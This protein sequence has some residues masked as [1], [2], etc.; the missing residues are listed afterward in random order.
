MDFE[1]AQQTI[2]R[3]VR[4]QRRRDT[5]FWCAF[6]C[7]VL[8]LGIAAKGLKGT[9]FY[10]RAID[11]GSIKHWA[12]LDSFRSYRGVTPQPTYYWVSEKEV[13]YFQPTGMGTYQGYLQQL[14]PVAS[15]PKI[16][17]RAIVRQGDIP[18]GLSPDRNWLCYF[19]A[20]RPSR[21]WNAANMSYSLIPL[22]PQKNSTAHLRGGVIWN[23]KGETTK[24]FFNDTI[25]IFPK[26]GAS[27][28]A[29]KVP[30]L[31]SINNYGRN[32]VIR[33]TE[34]NKVLAT[35]GMPYIRRHTTSSRGT[36]FSLQGMTLI[37]IDIAS[38]TQGK[39]LRRWKIMGPDEQE[40]GR[41]Y[42]SPNSDQILWVIHSNPRTTWDRIVR[43]YINL[44]SPDFKNRVQG[45]LTNIDGMGMK[46][47]FD[48]DAPTPDFGMRSEI[49]WVPEGKQISVALSDRLY[50]LPLQ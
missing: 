22:S 50:I 47:I 41:A 44:R 12:S 30:E 25:T 29:I 37:E 6:G 21:G 19:Q 43:R 3:I 24:P 48:F 7:A 39:V 8:G 10:S 9:D 27:P 20:I 31:T 40:Y 4:Q 33:L 35:L 11:L 45:Y 26:P 49:R 18:T 17:P 38:K 14:R 15:A 46:K 23:K 36:P 2:K 16:L 13:L 1:Q 34:D 5:Q 32:R 28:L 42:I